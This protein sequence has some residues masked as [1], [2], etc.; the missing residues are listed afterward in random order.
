MAGKVDFSD[1]E[2]KPM[3]LE[4]SE[5]AVI[6]WMIAELGNAGRTAAR[7]ITRIYDNLILETAQGFSPATAHEVGVYDI[8]GIE[9]EWIRDQLNKHLDDQ[10]PTMPVSLAR[11]AVRLSDKVSARLEDGTN[12]PLG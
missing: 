12:A 3:E 7:M 4:L 6:V 2:H 8:S 10:N 11:H 1:W 5:R 9:L